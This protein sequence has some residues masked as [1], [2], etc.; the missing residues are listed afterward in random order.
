MTRRRSVLVAGQVHSSITVKRSCRVQMGHGCV[1][2]A[3]HRG[4]ERLHVGLGSQL[5]GS[6]RQQVY[7]ISSY[8]LDVAALINIRLGAL[9]H[10]TYAQQA[11]TMGCRSTIASSCAVPAPQVYLILEYAARGELYKELQKVH[12]FDEKRTAT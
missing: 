5:Q 7:N 1:S 3:C 4:R 10:S 2:L 6:V 12:H 11:L 9:K 8:S